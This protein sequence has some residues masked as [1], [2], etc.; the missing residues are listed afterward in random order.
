MNNFI[1]NTL[2]TIWSTAEF[3][4]KTSEEKQSQVD[5]FHSIEW[6]VQTSRASVA[7]VRALAKANPKKLLNHILN[8]EDQS[9]D[10]QITR[11]TNYLRRYCGFH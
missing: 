11:T 1:E 4:Y 2:Y 8:A 9:I 7:W 3:N 5:A 10:S 6:Y